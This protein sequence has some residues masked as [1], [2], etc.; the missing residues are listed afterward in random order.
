MALDE[1]M[2]PCIKGGVTM[3]ALPEWFENIMKSLGKEHSD[4]NATQLRVLANL[5]ASISRMVYV[6][7][8]AKYVIS[9]KSKRY[10]RADDKLTT[11][12]LWFLK[13]REH[14]CENIR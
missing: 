14:R 12:E 4:L 8:E 11:A 1:W 10:D 9:T 13:N 5:V 2:V 6:R 3:K 7:G